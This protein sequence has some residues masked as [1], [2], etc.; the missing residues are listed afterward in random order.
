MKDEPFYKYTESTMPFS[1]IIPW[2]SGNPV[3]EQSF[4]NMM[5]CLMVQQTPANIEKITFE[6]IVVENAHKQWNTNTLDLI[7]EEIK[8][9]I[10]PVSKFTYK[11]LHTDAPA[12]NKSWCMNVGAR[13]AQYDNLIFFDADS[14]AG[15]D[16]I[17]TIKP[18]LKKIPY[19]KNQMVF[20]WNYLIKLNGK[21][22]PI[23][24]WVRPD[25]TRAMGGV[26]YS[27]KGFYWNNFGGMN[28]NYQGYGGEDNDAF[29]RAVWAMQNAG[30][31]DSYPAMVPYTLAHQYHDNEPQSAT[32][33]LWL[34][35]RA[36]PMEVIHRLK[37]QPLGDVSGPHF[38]QMNDLSG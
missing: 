14:I 30:C 33:P 36:N 13:L 29:E 9:S 2:R 21:D 12:F 24:R 7:P 16:W 25:V 8:N 19:P 20:L 38:I 22:D 1:I 27:T 11:I 35:A 10:Y 4:K 6:I 32:V 31:P 15:H 17:R 37:Q 18:E 5:N 28:E 34:K 26:W 23:P 3:R